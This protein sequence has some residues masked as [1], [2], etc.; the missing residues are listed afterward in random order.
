MTKC[1]SILAVATVALWGCAGRTHLWDAKGRAVEDQLAQ[2]RAPPAPGKRAGP[3]QGLDS[4]EASI[5]AGAYHH[6]LAPKGVKVE[7]QPTLLIAP[8]QP[9]QPMQGMPLPSVPKE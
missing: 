3:V 4:Q 1:P 5:I 8:P 2:Q 6:S 7:E 9:Y